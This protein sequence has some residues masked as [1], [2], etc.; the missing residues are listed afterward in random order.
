MKKVFLL[1]A[2]FCFISLKSQNKQVLYNFAG[3]PQTLLLNPGSEINYNFH[4]GIPL[5]SGISAEIG[6][7]GFSLANLFADDGININDKIETILKRLTTQDYG[8]LYAQVEVLNAGFRVDH[9]TYLSFGFYTEIDAFGYYPKDV[10]TLLNEGNSGYLNNNFLFSQIVYKLDVLGVL[11]FGASHQFTE[12]LTLG[13]R[14]KVYSSAVNMRSK[15]NTGSFVTVAGRENAYK[16]I[17]SDINIISNSSGLIRNDEFLNSAGDYLQNVFL[18]GNLGIGFDLGITY[19]INENLEFSGSILDIGFIHHTKDISNITAKGSFAYEGIQFQFD[20]N[21][22][23]I[24]DIEARFKRELVIAENE[25]SYVSLRPIKMNA[26]LMY[27]FGD[28]I[29]RKFDNYFTK[30][31]YTDAAGVQLHTVF[32]PLRPQVAL[33]AFYQKSLTNNLQTKV[34]YTVDD[35]SVS[36]IGAGISAQFKNVNLYG[37]VDNILSYRDLSKANN[38]SLQLGINLIFN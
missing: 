15:N 13:A 16:H 34:T 18:G 11:H 23:Y 27:R 32:R 9:R 36:N 26:A 14:F 31:F 21:Q 28:K 6:S 2:V 19:R 4:V 35:F 5:F 22:N 8:K 7:S 17:F 12:K 33:T 24:N 3:L 1:W 20:N 10:F 25:R 37:L 29:T 38:I 30:D